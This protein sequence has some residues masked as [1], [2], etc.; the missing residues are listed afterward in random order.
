MPLFNILKRS[1][2]DTRIIPMKY[3]LT[4][5]EISQTLLGR[6]HTYSTRALISSKKSWKNNPWFGNPLPIAVLD[7][8]AAKKV[9]SIR[10]SRSIL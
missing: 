10:L 9:K 4:K 8:A 5:F 2:T 7:A 1:G 3:V 6:K